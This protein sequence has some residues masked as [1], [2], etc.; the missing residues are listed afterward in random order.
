MLEMAKQ[1]VGV[2]ELCYWLAAACVPGALVRDH[3]PRST[4]GPQL[5]IDPTALRTLQRKLA[6]AEGGQEETNYLNVGVGDGNG[7]FLRLCDVLDA[8]APGADGGEDGRQVTF[9]GAA[10]APPGPAG[11]VTVG[12][13]EYLRYMCAAI[14]LFS[15]TGLPA[16]TVAAAAHLWT[17]VTDQWADP[18]AFA[19]EFH[20]LARPLHTAAS[21]LVWALEAAAGFEPGHSSPSTRCDHPALVPEEDADALHEERMG[22]VVGSAPATATVTATGT[23]AGSVAGGGTV[24]FHPGALRGKDA[25]E[26]F[27]ALAVAV[28]SPQRALQEYLD[29]SKAVLAYLL[30]VVPVAP[31]RDAFLAHPSRA[32]LPL[33]LSPFG[34]LPLELSLC[35]VLWLLREFKHVVEVGSRAISLYMLAAPSE[36]SRG[37]GKHVLH[38]MVDAQEQLV[39][40]AEAFLQLQTDNLDAFVR[41]WEDAQAKKR[42]KKLRIARLEKSDEELAFEADKGVLQMKMYTASSVLDGRNARLK[43]LRDLKKRFEASYSMGWSLISKVPLSILVNHRSSCQPLSALVSPRQSHSTPFCPL[44]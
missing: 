17:F 12:R 41:E 29:A 4:D 15:L 32:N 2:A 11:D 8:A 18:I 28:P 16:A 24:N 36:H 1:V 22:T 7:S 10:G 21:A 27:N 42:K 37:L 35:Q 34:A 44:S 13:Q 6:P 43:E 30:K 20:A 25:M 9:T 14:S 5:R 19:I 40:Q 31:G 39:E 26:N 3:A 23:A 33:G 38:L